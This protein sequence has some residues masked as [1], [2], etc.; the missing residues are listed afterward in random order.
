MKNGPFAADADRYHARMD[1]IV[2]GAGHAGL[3]TSQRLRVAG[4][5]HLVIERGRVAE[6]WRSQRWDTFTL[7]TPTSANGLTGDEEADLGE[8]R[9][10][11]MT[12]AELVERLTR[13]AERW[14]LPIQGGTEVLD[15]EVT[16]RGS[17]EVRVR[18]HRWETIE[19]RAVLVASG[20]QNVT[21]T[22][23]IAS[24][25]PADVQ[26]VPAL[27]YKRADALPPGA[28][29]V[30]GGGQTGAQV[31]EDLLESGRTV[32]WSLSKVTRVPRRYRGRDILEWLIDGGFYAQTTESIADKAQLRATMPIVS[33]LGRY[34]HTV[35]LQWL[36][37]RGV[38]LIGRI[39]T[40][41]GHVL[42]L[43]GSV[44]D[45]V[46]FGDERSKQ[47]REMI[48]G[49][50][51]KLVGR[52]PPLEQDDADVPHP[53]PDAI[54]SP[55]SL[56]MATAGVTSV[57]WATG[58]RGDYTYLPDGAVGEDGSPIHDQGVSPIE[59]IYYIGL[60]WQSRRGSGIMHG[61]T[62]DAEAIAAAVSKRLKEESI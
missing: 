12:A 34:G 10:G 54:E 59:G 38:T 20:V 9:D 32:Y 5:E 48:D 35:S 16:D 37:G 24:S 25:F 18:G 14:D 13:Y 6:S 50:I 23:P 15:V 3:A 52:L 27:E 58:V 11:F 62:P 8:P 61:I 56:D 4:I 31:A 28:V 22:A 17:F 33:G 2:I 36:A 41:E 1:A 49:I 47:I 21:R 53:H 43:D 42:Q 19:T 29:L 45:C 46:R 51:E 39:T 44:A 55:A 26:Q 40:I 57:I 30:V 60:P 7:N